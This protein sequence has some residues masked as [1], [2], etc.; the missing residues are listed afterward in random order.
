MGSDELFGFIQQVSNDRV[1][2]RV[3]C[4]AC[5]YLPGHFL[6]E[7]VDSSPFENRHMAYVFNFTRDWD[8]DYGGLTHFLDDD[9]QVVDTFIPD[10]NTLTLFRVPV[11]HSVSTVAAFAPRPRYSITGWFTRY[12]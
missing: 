5:Q 6:K 2:N 8:A 1:F 3:D 7:H 12:N 9:H 4:H 11:P 10:F